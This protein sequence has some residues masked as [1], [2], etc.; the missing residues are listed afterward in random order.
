[1]APERTAWKRSDRIPVS[2]EGHSG[3]I[4]F[5]HYAQDARATRHLHPWGMTTNTARWWASRP[6]V[7]SPYGVQNRGLRAQL[8]ATGAS[9]AVPGHRVA[10]QRADQAEWQRLRRMVTERDGERCAVEGCDHIEDLQ[11]DHIWRGSLL[12]AVGW[13]PSAINDP[14]NLQLLCP[15]HHADKTAHESQLIAADKTHADS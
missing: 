5:R 4:D 12:A 15:V 7:S 11:L 3:E 1:L 13:S 6:R 14:I 9:A 2:R 10:H 8:G